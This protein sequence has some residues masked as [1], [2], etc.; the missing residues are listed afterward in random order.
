MVQGHIQSLQLNQYI[1]SFPV[2]ATSQN[3]RADFVRKQLL[4]MKEA[5]EQS[6]VNLTISLAGVQVICP[7]NEAE[8]LNTLVGKAFRTAYAVQ[9]SEERCQDSDSSPYKTGFIQCRRSKDFPQSRSAE[10]LLSSN[11]GFQE[12]I[13]ETTDF[14]R[15]S[16]NRMSDNTL[17]RARQTT[18]NREN[19]R[20]RSFQATGIRAQSRLLPTVPST[21]NHIDNLISPA[22]E[23]SQTSMTSSTKSF[24]RFRP[25]KP[26]T[27][28]VLNCLFAALNNNDDDTPYCEVPSSLMF[29]NN[30]ISDDGSKLQ[31][32]R[33]G[34]SVTHDDFRISHNGTPTPPS[35]KST[36]YM[37]DS[38]TTNS[39]SSGDSLPNGRVP[40]F[41][42]HTMANVNL[43]KSKSA[44][45]ISSSEVYSEVADSMTLANKRT[46]RRPPNWSIDELRPFPSGFVPGY[47]DITPV[48]D[49]PSYLSSRTN[50]G[51][52]SGFS[53]GDASCTNSSGTTP[54]LVNT[55]VQL[56][57][58][59]DS[60]TVHHENGLTPED[61][62]SILDEPELESAPWFQSG[63][64][65]DLAL[66][67][68][69]REPEG[70]FL[71]RESNSRNTGLAL[72]VRVPLD[73]HPGGI[74]HYLIIRAPKGFK[75][76]GCPKQFPSI[77]SLLV[78]HS[79]MPEMLPCPLSLNRYNP[80]FR[81]GEDDSGA[82]A[83][84]GGDYLDPDRDYEL[85]AQLR[86]GLLM[87]ACQRR[88]VPA[89]EESPPTTVK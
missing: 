34:S 85:I 66:E 35:Q 23:M 63:M 72:S 74:A 71:V 78:H 2:Q 68:L 76:K 51:H 3:G 75:I 69:S 16:R 8:D 24:S 49:S 46:Q 65:R 42:S 81:P 7:D 29:N 87:S 57:T 37:H 44:H 6:P 43:G 15:E 38:S 61:M 4:H 13:Y 86:E 77:T 33:L 59:G 79:V 41:N 14:A 30:H 47:R 80:T 84:Q 52:S 21:S 56:L 25:I 12:P 20:Y 28:P 67:V 22:S 27:L 19:I 62:E 36:S 55:S 45:L 89:M 5:L 40:G 32:K 64:P 82:S 18:L 54:P 17:A 48:S 26:N 11:G 88:G 10:S 31:M 73:F 58:L 50:R 1:G 70:A 83:D 60:I 9:L 39:E 53:S